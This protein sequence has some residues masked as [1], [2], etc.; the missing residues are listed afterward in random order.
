MR[1]FQIVLRGLENLAV[2]Q[3]RNPSVS[4]SRNPS[5]SRPRNPSASQEDNYI[6]LVQIICM[7]YLYMYFIKFFL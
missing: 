3:S 7:K 1:L 6:C 5:A 4:Q 2:S